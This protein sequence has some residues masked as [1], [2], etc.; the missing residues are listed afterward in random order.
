ME[1]FLSLSLSLLLTSWSNWFVRRV[2]SEKWRLSNHNDWHNHFNIPRN[3]ITLKWRKKERKKN[4]IRVQ[5]SPMNNHSALK[6]RRRQRSLFIAPFDNVWQ[7]V[8]LFQHLLR[9]Y[10]LFGTQLVPSEREKNSIE[11]M[12]RE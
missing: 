10:E 12:A 8:M 5:I 9:H 7:G 11:W 4:E 6:W 3:K 2:T 1:F